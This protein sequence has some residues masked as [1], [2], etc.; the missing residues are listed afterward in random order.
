MKYGVNLSKD[1]NEIRIK[2]CRSFYEL[3]TRYRL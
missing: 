3:E 1:K 2:Y